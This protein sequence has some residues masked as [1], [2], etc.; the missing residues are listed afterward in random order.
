MCFEISTAGGQFHS[1]PR[2]L[3]EVCGPGLHPYLELSYVDLHLGFYPE[4]TSSSIN[5]SKEKTDTP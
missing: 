5:I 2:L 1:W 3:S 4:L